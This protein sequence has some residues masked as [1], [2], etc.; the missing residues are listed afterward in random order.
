M[1]NFKDMPPMYA[2]PGNTY[3]PLMLKVEA[4]KP[5]WC[6]AD[7]CGDDWEECPVNIAVALLEN[8]G[9]NPC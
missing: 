3:G 7:C 8:L 1:I 9:Q 6:V 4:G 5:Y 2:G